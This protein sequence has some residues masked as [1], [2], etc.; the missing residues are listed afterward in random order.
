VTVHRPLIVVVVLA[1]AACGGEKDGAA[2]LA[3]PTSSTTERVNETTEKAETTTTK[4][5]PPE[6]FGI[7]SRVETSRGNFITLHAYEQPVVPPEFFEPESG[8]EYAAADVEFCAAVDPPESTGSSTYPVNPFDFELV[9]GDNTRRQADMGV[10]E[11]T[12]NHTEVAVGDCVRGWVTYQ[13]PAGIRPASLTVLR[14][15]PI[16]KFAL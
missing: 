5:P 9:M 2:R 12:L 11:P 6:T 1:L 13:V 8:Q 16:V 14:T 10:K 7:G 15:D 3:E 4:A